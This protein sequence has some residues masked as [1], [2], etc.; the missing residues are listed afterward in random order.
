MLLYRKGLYFGADRGNYRMRFFLGFTALAALASASAAQ[1]TPFDLE[2]VTPGFYAG[3]ISV[4]D[5]S[6][7][8][9]ITADGGAQSL[10]VGNSSVA[11][12][13]QAVIGSFTNPLATNQFS[14]VRFSFNQ[15]IS[16]ITFNFGD[17]GGD[18]DSPV[19][20]SAYDAGNVLL[21]TSTAA[22]PAGDASGGSLVLNFAGASYF[23]ASSGVAGNNANSVFWDI[24]EV[25][26]G[27]GGVPEPA[28]WALMIVGFGMAGAALRR[29]AYRL[30]EKTADGRSLSESFVAV[31]DQAAVAQAASVAE[32]TSFEVW[33][34]KT[35]IRGISTW[36]PSVA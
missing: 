35:L 17:G 15:S 32:G 8:L 11:L 6:L 29:R 16:S 2:N 25:Q 21:G 27:G 33:R 24:G 5:G 1:A 9:S 28:S 26:A 3:P 10:Y 4:S 19:V 12:L 18:S 36:G 31:N 30:V 14:P 13:G 34:D 23:I 22:Y 7:V 20:I